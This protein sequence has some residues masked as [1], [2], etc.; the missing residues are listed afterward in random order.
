LHRPVSRGG[1]QRRA[2]VID[3]LLRIDEGHIL[4]VIEALH[5][6]DG[7]GHERARQL[8]GYLD[9]FSTLSTTEMQTQG[10]C[11]SALAKERAPIDISLK[12]A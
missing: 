3:A 4:E 1:E 11:P 10:D 5:Q 6:A 7:P 12:S 9:R 2:W 8:A